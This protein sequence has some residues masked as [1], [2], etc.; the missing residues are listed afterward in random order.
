[1]IKRPEWR[2]SFG[3]GTFLVINKELFVG[4]ALENIKPGKSHIHSLL[5]VL[6]QFL[7]SFISP[8]SINIALKISS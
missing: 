5:R 3:T 6:I 1:M 8:L 4:F 2:F 7:I